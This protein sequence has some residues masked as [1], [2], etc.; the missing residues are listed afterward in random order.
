MKVHHSNAAFEPDSPTGSAGGGNRSDSG[1]TLK[2][3][4]SVDGD[5]SNGN[6]RANQDLRLPKKGEEEEEEKAGS[7]TSG[8][9]PHK[10]SL[11]KTDY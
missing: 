11:E 3:V 1:V 10:C 5:G 8:V 9:S 2:S 7:S 6:W 4:V